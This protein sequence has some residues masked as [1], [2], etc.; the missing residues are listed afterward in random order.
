MQLAIP[1]RSEALVKM[2]QELNSFFLKTGLPEPWQVQTASTGTSGA[3]PSRLRSRFRS[4]I[5]KTAAQENEEE[6][7]LGP[8]FLQ[9]SLRLSLSLS[10]RCKSLFL[11]TVG[12]L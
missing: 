11:Y 2:Q 6:L 10:L 7:D 12:I 1:Q 4:K 9:V 5:S 8:S 3:R